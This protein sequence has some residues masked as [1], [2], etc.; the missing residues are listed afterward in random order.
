MGD[1]KI[2]IRGNDCIILFLTLVMR[3]ANDFHF[4]THEIYS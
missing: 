4:V 2:V 3:F 1:I